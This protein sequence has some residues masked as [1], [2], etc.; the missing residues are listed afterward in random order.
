V[1]ILIT[2]HYMNILG[3]NKNCKTGK[4]LALSSQFFLKVLLL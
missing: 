1:L 4:N 2:V 3:L